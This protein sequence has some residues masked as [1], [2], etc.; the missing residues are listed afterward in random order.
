MNAITHI[1][2]VEDL[3]DVSDWLSRIAAQCFPDASVRRA[4]SLAS[5][6]ELLPTWPAQLAL[7][8]IGL[9]DGSGVALIPEIL[10]KNP[11]CSCVITTI[12]DDSEHLFA[13][14]KAGAEGYLLKD[15]TTEVFSQRLMGILA[16]QPPL[17][18]SIARRMLAFFRPQKAIEYNLTARESEVLTLIAHGYSVRNAAESLQLSHHT[19]ADYLKDIYR[20]L[21][22]NSRAEA[23]LKAVDLGL[24]TL[25]HQ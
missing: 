15:E 25:R 5:A 20:K 1:L 18:P 23:T 21:Q 10:A 12:F 8:D 13:A 4:D 6:R 7:L 19:V 11:Q 2:I 24:I 3:P 16:G 17:S 9:P 22:V 14:L